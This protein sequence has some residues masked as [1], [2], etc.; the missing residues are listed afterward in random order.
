MPLDIETQPMDAGAGAFG[1]IYH[2]EPD[3]GNARTLPNGGY[4]ISPVDVIYLATAANHEN[5][6][7]PGRTIWTMIR[8]FVAQYCRMTR[9]HK[10]K[11]LVETFSQPVNPA[12]AYIEH[13]ATGATTVPGTVVNRGNNLS[14]VPG[15]PTSG[16]RRN[17][18]RAREGGR[19]GAAVSRQRNRQAN[20]RKMQAMAQGG[21]EGARQWRGLYPSVREA[22]YSILRGGSGPP[23]GF[24]DGFDD[25]ASYNIGTRRIDIWELSEAEQRRILSNTDNFLSQRVSGGRVGVRA[26][27]SPRVSFGQRGVRFYNR[28]EWYVYRSFGTD[29]NY[30]TVYIIGEDGNSL[31][32][33]GRL[34][35]V[36][37][38]ERSS[39]RGV[40]APA[41]VSGSS[42]S[43]DGSAT[44]S[45]YV[46]TSVV[47]NTSFDVWDV[48]EESQI[49]ENMR[50]WAEDSKRELGEIYR[51]RRR[52]V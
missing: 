22:V 47:Q 34:F 28:G 43:S 46:Q 40:S 19:P 30:G 16:G 48:L 51:G 6:G 25:F 39:F 45:S 23:A 32:G 3:G 29:Y 15:N 5:R 24:A 4:E 18:L 37:G 14:A 26:D 31:S 50:N 33:P 9:D 52:I 7:E 2:R 42:S 17:A 36:G 49:R 11:R 12:W 8:R 41:S 44:G 38:D 1:R 27:G 35:A 13:W 21:A 10:L 20:I